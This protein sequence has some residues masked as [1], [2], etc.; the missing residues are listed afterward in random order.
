[1]FSDRD[2]V[3]K[4]KINEKIESIRKDIKNEDLDKTINVKNALTKSKEL[5]AMLKG[6]KTNVQTVGSD[7]L[8]LLEPII[9]RSQA[10]SDIL[11]L[12]RSQLL[13]EAMQQFISLFELMLPSLVTTLVNS[14]NIRHT[15]LEKDKEEK[16]LLQKLFIYE[17]Y[18]NT[19]NPKDRLLLKSQDKE[20]SWIIRNSANMAY[21]LLLYIQEILCNMQNAH[22]I[23][24]TYL[25]GKTQSSDKKNYQLMDNLDR[26]ALFKL[27]IITY[28]FCP[29]T[30]EN[31][32]IKNNI[33]SLLA[34]LRKPTSP[35]SEEIPIRLIFTPNN[36]FG[37]SLGKNI[38][39]IERILNKK[40]AVARQVT[41]DSLRCLYFYL[42]WQKQISSLKK[43]EKPK[44]LDMLPQ[45]IIIY[46]I[47]FIYPKFYD[48]DYI[49]LKNTLSFVTEYNK[50]FLKNPSKK[51]KDFV[52]SL[53]TIGSDQKKPLENK[54]QEMK[55]QITTF[56]SIT[57]KGKALSLLTNYGLLEKPS[58]EK[59]EKIEKKNNNTNSF[60]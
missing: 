6:E 46:I 40:N 2:Q 8:D 4:D 37:I 50:R 7:I 19:N 14:K 38:S 21:E 47:R 58:E 35:N 23:S 55:T 52:N 24:L 20:I 36:F 57:K 18:E 33:L 10:S 22:L 5:I 3:L 29:D 41:N 26:T 9:H 31:S 43:D 54:A 56:G 27:I 17:S 34:S 59:E 25:T 60:T 53:A 39:E 32:L 45:E 51:S 44:E 13:N 11:Q 12:P 15:L 42:G 48:K 16:N 49:F 28:L 1:M 30:N